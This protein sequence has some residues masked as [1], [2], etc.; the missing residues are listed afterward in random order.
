MLNSFQTPNLALPSAGSMAISVA[1]DF[2]AR[3]AIAGS[4]QQE[5][6]DDRI[7]LIQSIYIDNADNS[8]VMDLTLLGAPIPQRIRAQANTQGWYPLS[9]PLGNGAYKAVS[10]SGAV[11]N[12]IFANYAMP[13]LVWGPP[14]GIIVVP[15]LANVAL[16]ALNFAGAG[17]K[18]LV[19]GVAAQTVKLYRGIFSVDA[20]TTLTWTDGPGGTV[21]FAAFLTAGGSATFEVSGVPWFNAGAGHDLTLHSTAACNVY[22]GFGYVQS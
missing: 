20:P 9:W 21:L 13:Y 17:D 8:S 1:L 5:L 3:A 10:N 22:G 12:V 19:A 7:E 4:L 2:T 14:S 6:L 18:Q 15:A 11:I 16:N